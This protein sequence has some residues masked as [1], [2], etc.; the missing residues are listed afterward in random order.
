MLTISDH[1]G[2]GFG[3][4]ELPD[5]LRQLQDFGIGNQG[6]VYFVEGNTGSNGNTGDSWDQAYKTLANAIT[7]S[8]ANIANGDKKGYA[9][10]NT[11]F[12]KGD[13][14]DED[15]VIFPN[16]C[17]VIGVGS[18]DAYVGAGIIGNHEPANADNYGTRFINMNFFPQANGDIVTIASTSSGVQFINC[19][20]IGVWGAITAPS[21]IQITASPMAKIIGCKLFG[22]FSGDVIDICAGDASGMEIT[23]NKIIGGADNGI[24]VSGEATVA[25]AMS[26]G[27][28]A[29][30]E[31]QVADKVI[32]TRAV[33][34]FNC[35][36]N[37]CISGEVDGAG[38]YVID[39]TYAVNNKITCADT[40]VIVPTYSELIT[41]TGG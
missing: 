20:G 36:D 33:S 30:N 26:R 24:V 4:G 16:K 18:C 7:V 12:V 10:R 39:P 13:R 9:S 1:V 29:R 41:H 27:T 5:I 23:D 37:T 25:G 17:D 8:N 38:S 32:D 14:L 40:C 15:L 19:V 11:I 34:V 31:I 6:E 35:H 3:K 21:F 2:Q 22:A 28:I